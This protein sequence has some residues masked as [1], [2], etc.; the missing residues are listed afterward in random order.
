MD[1][2]ELGA[3]QIAAEESGEG[4]PAAVGT[5]VSESAQASTLEMRPS[6]GEQKPKAQ[7]QA[8]GKAKAGRKAEIR[9][10]GNPMSYELD[11]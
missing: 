3:A 2:K 5:L 9:F 1:R 10:A 8:A 6:I 7:P 4:L 11:F